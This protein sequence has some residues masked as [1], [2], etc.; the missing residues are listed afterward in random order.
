MGD[1]IPAML[2]NLLLGGSG[3]PIE[4]AGFQGSNPL[5]HMQGKQAS[6]LLDNLSSP[7]IHFLSFQI[8]CDLPCVMIWITDLGAHI[9]GNQ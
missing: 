7:Q 1:S 3:N 5:G 8:P 4:Q 9:G 6:C 2:R